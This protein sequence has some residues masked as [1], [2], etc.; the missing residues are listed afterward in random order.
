MESSTR[1]RLIPPMTASLFGF[2]ALRL[3]RK[4]RGSPRCYKP[5]SFPVGEWFSA[6]S[7]M[8]D[9]HHNQMGVPRHHRALKPNKDGKNVDVV[10]SREIRG[11]R[12]CD[13]ESRIL[14]GCKSSISSVEKN[15]HN[16]LSSSR[17]EIADLHE[18]NPR[19]V[20]GLFQVVMLYQVDRKLA[21]RNVLEWVKVSN[22]ARTLGWLTKQGSRARDCDPHQ[23]DEK[24]GVLIIDPR[25]G[26]RAVS[27]V[28][29]LVGSG[30]VEAQEIEDQGIS[31]GSLSMEL[32][33][34]E[35]LRIQAQRF[36][37]VTQVK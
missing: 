7:P 15:Q 37:G 28:D 36:S 33:A 31:L 1:K 25:D 24:V 16:N 26:G 13:P 14:V 34:S 12:V 17:A 19:R 9:T 32:F 6:L 10:I 4:K 20:V 21:K 2:R 3:A 23:L 35:L 29:D 8:S 22:V 27:N 30:A 5:V 18:Y 11:T